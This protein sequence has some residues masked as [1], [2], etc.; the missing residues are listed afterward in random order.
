MKLALQVAPQ[1]TPLGVLVTTPPPL[2]EIVRVLVLVAPLDAPELLPL[3]LLV[4][5]LEL[6]V[7]PPEL[8]VVPLE[9]LVVPLELLVVPLE[10]LVLPL[11]L[12]VLPLELLV[13]PLELLVLPLELLVLPL[14][15]LPLELPWPSRPCLPVLAAS[16]VAATVADGLAAVDEVPPPPHAW[17]RLTSTSWPATRPM[18]LANLSLKW[19]VMVGSVKRGNFLHAKRITTGHPRSKRFFLYKI[20]FQ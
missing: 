17:R 18:R 10:L 6:L 1:L 5:P 7:V 11:E 13:V 9:L 14:E 3:E 2:V 20:C 16:A 19:G 4:V 12:L 15:L 8:L